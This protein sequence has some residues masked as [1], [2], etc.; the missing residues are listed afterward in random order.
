M[1]RWFA[2][3]LALAMLAGL[4]ACGSGDDGGQTASAPAGKTEPASEAEAAPIDA[5]VGLDGTGYIPRMDGTVIEIDGDVES[6]VLT[7][8]RSRV[9]VLETDGDLYWAPADDPAASTRIGTDVQGVYL[10]SSGVVYITGDEGYEHVSVRRYSFETGTSVEVMDEEATGEVE[11]FAMSENSL[12]MLLADGQGNVRLYREDGDG[13]EHLASYTDEPWM[14]YVSDDGSEAVWVTVS[15]QYNDYTESYDS[16]STYYRFYNGEREKLGSTDSYSYGPTLF[17]TLDKEFFVMTDSQSDTLY[18]W[19]AGQ[20]T[21]SARMGSQMAYNA[22]V[23]TADGPLRQAQSAPEDGLYVLVSTAPDNYSSNSVY[24]VDANGDRE[25][26]VSD[27]YNYQICQGR[28]FYLTSD[29]DLYTATVEGSMLGES[30]KIASGVQAY[31]VSW[32]AKTICYT[33]DPDDEYTCSLYW[34]DV[35][36]DSNERLAT[37]VP[38]YS[39]YMSRDGQSVFYMQ[40]MDDGWTGSLMRA[41]RAKS[42]SGSAPTWRRA[43]WTAAIRT[44]STPTPL[45]F[46]NIWEQTRPARAM[47]PVCII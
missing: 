16:E 39:V 21:V 19:H 17:H 11:S 13:S 28:M 37:G 8:D 32:D 15:E 23:Y 27:V 29:D 7:V 18:F 33:K 38:T 14:T 26:V 6:A 4:T 9:V 42:P 12:N 45:C 20:P 3:L 31:N 24:F 40:D 34:Y 43:C 44:A 30:V 36:N 46:G 10:R 22:E 5:V 35:E 1:R 2:L 47:T 41:Q 25:R